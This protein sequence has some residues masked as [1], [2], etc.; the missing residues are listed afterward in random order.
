[1]ADIVD[2]AIQAGNFKTLVAALQAAGLSDAL[3]E[4]GPF[5]VFAPSDDAFG[6]LPPGTLDDLLKPENKDKLVKILTYH[7][8]A[9]RYMAA[10]VKQLPD[11]AKV[12]TLSGQSITVT[13]KGDD[14]FVDGAKVIAAD[15]AAD[16]G[17]IHVI[18]AVILPPDL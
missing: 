10:D 15:A 12:P 8:V 9:G 3:K 7:V 2:T 5:T 16:N 4:P 1:M 18:D 11:G 14:I 13:F 6:K 17:V